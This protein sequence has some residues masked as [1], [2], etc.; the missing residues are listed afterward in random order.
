[1]VAPLVMGAVMFAVTRS[2]LSIMFVALSPLLMAGNYV[3]GRAARKRKLRDA[4]K[5]FDEQLRLLEE[6]LAGEEAAERGVRLAEA[7]ATAEVTRAA[8]DLGNLVWTRRP[9]HWAFLSFRIGLGSLGSRNQ[10]SSRAKR[11]PFRS[12]WRACAT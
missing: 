7:P 8:G 3:A 9:E 5:K 6:A 11:R 2:A 1:M 10:G 12:S 4:E